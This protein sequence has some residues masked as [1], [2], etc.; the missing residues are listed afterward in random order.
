MHNSIKSRLQGI[1]SV[2][3]TL[4]I[5]TNRDM[6][7]YLGITCHFIESYKLASPMV[8]CTGFRGRQTADNIVEKYEEV[9]SSFELC[10]NV[11]ASNMKKAFLTLPGMKI[12]PDSDFEEES[13]ISVIDADLL[14]Y[15][16]EHSS[17]LCHTL[18]LVVKD[19]FQEADQQSD[20]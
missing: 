4:D 6:R 11:K 18:Q 9:M 2:C 17:C 5:W 13:Q 8:A 15:I 16:P 12:T 19:A 1:D 14:I 10:G 3:V 7:S 20:G